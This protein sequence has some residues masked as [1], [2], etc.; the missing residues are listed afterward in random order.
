[1]NNSYYK[2]LGITPTTDK[3]AV[4]KAY[5]R[6]AKQFH[7]DISEHVNA[8]EKFIEA[9]KAYESIMDRLERPLTYR[10]Y[11]SVGKKSAYRKYKKQRT[12]KYGEPDKRAREYAKMRYEHFQKASQAAH[13]YPILKHTII[14]LAGLCFF[15]PVIAISIAVGSF[16]PLILVLLVGGSIVLFSE[17]RGG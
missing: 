2:V 5:R 3:A 17:G 1:M 15:A 13:P 4:K 9:T 7:P 10:R 12:A 8:E 16:T 14:V 11:T 6:L